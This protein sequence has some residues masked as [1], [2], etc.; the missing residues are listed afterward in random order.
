MI[1]RRRASAPGTRRGSRTYRAGDGSSRTALSA[2]RLLQTTRITMRDSHADRPISASRRAH[3]PTRLRRVLDPASPHNYAL[4]PVRRTYG[5]AAVRASQVR[6]RPAAGQRPGPPLLPAQCDLRQQR[7]AT[8]V[9][10][11]YGARS[12]LPVRKGAGQRPALQAHTRPVTYSN[13]ATLAGAPGRIRTC[14]HGS[15]EGC[16]ARP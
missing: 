13:L 8:V 15:G 2:L 7:A 9:W 4:L 5:S 6:S 16:Y 14:A 12:W 11:A 10:G 1:P 3:P